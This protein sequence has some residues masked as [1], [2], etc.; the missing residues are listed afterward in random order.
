MSGSCTFYPKLY[1]VVGN[2]LIESI[3][4]LV[5]KKKG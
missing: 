4:N 3:D 1:T 5:E 2:I